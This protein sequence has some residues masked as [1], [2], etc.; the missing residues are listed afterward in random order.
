MPASPI[1]IRLFSPASSALEVV[2]PPVDRIA[3]YW[4]SIEPILARATNRTKSYAPIDIL[5]RVFLGQMGMWLVIEGDKIIAVA[6][7]E[8]RQFPR[9]RVLEVPFIAGHGLKRWHEALLDALDKQAEA[10]GC[11]DI[12]GFDRRG[13]ARFGFRVTGVTLQRSVGG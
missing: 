11:S 13:W 2:A 1:P 5:H 8:V 6:I 12:H 4:P 9:N 7:T 10:L 3:R